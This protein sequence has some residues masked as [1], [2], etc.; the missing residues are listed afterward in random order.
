MNIIK[1]IK[2]EIENSK[3]PTIKLNQDVIDFVKKFK[4]S[5][6]LLRSGGIDIDILDKLAFGF[7][8]IEIKKINPI[9]LKIEWKDDIENVKYEIKHSKLTPKQWASNIDLTEPI[10]VDF[11]EINGKRGFYIQDGHHRYTAAK[12]LNKE[13]NVNLNIKIN[14][15]KELAPYLS[16]DEFH[17]CIFNQVNNLNEDF[18][19]VDKSNIYKILDDYDVKDYHIDYYYGQDNYIATLYKKNENKPLAEVR[20]RIYNNEINITII[21]S[22]VKGKG[23]GKILMIYLAKKYGYEKLERSSLTNDGYKMRKV[24]DDLFNFDYKAYVESKNKLIKMDE[25][26]KIKNKTIRTFLFN[27]IEK[28]TSAW[29]DYNNIK[30]KIGDV[31]IND[32]AEIAY[33]VKGSVLAPKY[34]EDDPPVWVLETL[35]GLQ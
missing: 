6:D 9:L 20:Y 25:I 26:K 17:R 23:Y 3:C 21:K 16:Y 35:K 14:P 31:E 8:E 7:N 10:D 22:L 18:S 5:E 13:L 34:S 29:D 24:L 1:I 15:I 12:I 2:E 19:K 32:V 28:G 4:S 30:D 27:L 11:K 33:Y